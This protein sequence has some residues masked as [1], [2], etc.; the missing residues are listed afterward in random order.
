MDISELGAVGELIGSLGVV[1]SLLYLSTQIR[2]NTRSVQA[3]S[4]QTVVSGVNQVNRL[5]I[6]EDALPSLVLRGQQ[7]LAALTPEE[8]V[9]FGAF[10]GHVI[11]N[12]EI[13]LHLHQRGLLDA[14][15]FEAHRASV[16]GILGA[17]GARHWWKMARG[18]MSN[19][20]RNHLDAEL[21]RVA[22]DLPPAE[23]S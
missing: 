2:H 15:S 22:P 9:R 6:A 5:L 1:V 3:A 23:S 10:L 21:Q 17:A 7:D 20:L 14:D 11:T 13:A 8:R 18:S 16:V 19:S 12:H 4:Y